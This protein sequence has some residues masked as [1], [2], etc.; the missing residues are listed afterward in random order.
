MTKAGNANVGEIHNQ[1]LMMLAH[2]IFDPE[3]N[4]RVLVDHAFIVAGGEITKPACAGSATPSTRRNGAG[5]Y[6]WAATTSGGYARSRA[7]RYRR[8]TRPGSTGGQPCIVR[9]PACQSPDR[10]TVM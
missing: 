2:D 6:S 9:A 8:G 1:V 10:T 4:K 7:S 3:V 5:S